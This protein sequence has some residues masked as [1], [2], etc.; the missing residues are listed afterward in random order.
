VRLNAISAA[1]VAGSLALMAVA[2][3]RWISALPLL[4]AS[5]VAVP[6]LLSPETASTPDSLAD[7]E[8][9]LVDNDVFRFANGPSSSPYE[10]AVGDVLTGARD[11]APR[12]VRPMLVLK[13]IV[14]G[15]PWQAVIEGLPGQSAAVVT[16]TGEKFEG[17]VV[18]SVTRDSVIVQASDT[19]WVLAFRKRS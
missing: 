16:R 5:P 15:P 19:T 18:R 14:G 1:L 10:P 9:T 2:R 8:A 3:Q 4:H 11:V 13:A 6:R 12:T 7:W 17:L